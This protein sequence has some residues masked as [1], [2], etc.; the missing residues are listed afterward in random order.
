MI[1]SKKKRFSFINSPFKSFKVLIKDFLKGKNKKDKIFRNYINEKLKISEKTYLTHGD[2]EET[3][4]KYEIFIVG[5]DQVWNPLITDSDT[6][7]L[8][9]FLPEES[10]IFSYAASMGVG[11]VNEKYE[12]A[13]RKNISRFKG[14]SVREKQ[15]KNY[16]ENLVP[17]DIFIHPDPSLLLSQEEWGDISIDPEYNN[18]ILIYSLRPGDEIY[19]LAAELSLS[20]DLD[21]VEIATGLKRRKNIKYT[22]NIGPAE[23]IGLFKN[24]NYVLTNSFHGTIFSVIFKK[25]FFVELCKTGNTWVNT[26]MTEFLDSIGLS[27]RYKKNMTLSEI[28]K[29]IDYYSI[30]KILEEKKSVGIKYLTRICNID[31]VEIKSYE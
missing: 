3:S 20:A 25:Q 21:I 19:S 27:S 17:N 7:Y 11:K 23:F 2:L 1:K 29:K 12:L 4:D 26:R 30:E 16:L 10:N 13:I 14:I 6:A 24:A 31:S 5:S 28:T 18:Y 22:K 9:S 15:T 8:F